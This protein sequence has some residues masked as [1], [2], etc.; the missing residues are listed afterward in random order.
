MSS[1]IFFRLL[2]IYFNRF[3]LE[4]KLGYLQTRF[5]PMQVHNKR[6]ALTLHGHAIQPISIVIPR[7]AG[8]LTIPRTIRKELGTV[9]ASPRME[10]A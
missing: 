8:K 10:Q 9:G 5:S 4:V 2:V 7:D 1:S 3:G 6:A